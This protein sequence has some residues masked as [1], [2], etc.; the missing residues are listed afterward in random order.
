MI[1]LSGGESISPDTIREMN[2]QLN[3]SI[4]YDKEM[5]KNLKSEVLGWRS[6]Q[7]R[8][9]VMMPPVSKRQVFFQYD[10]L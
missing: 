10:K 3:A 8:H 4:Y 5:I 7:Y 9:A 1:G 2:H 6:Y